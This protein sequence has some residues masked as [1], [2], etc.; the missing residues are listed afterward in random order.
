MALKRIMTDDKNIQLIQDNVDAA[1]IPIQTALMATAKVITNVTLTSG[2]DNLIAHQ[3]GRTPTIFFIGNLKVNSV[4]WS[5]TTTTL[6][7]SNWDSTRINLRCST[8]CVVTVW[9]N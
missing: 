3:L 1:L 4:V 6:H 8:T 9:I 5:P 7:G 2:Q